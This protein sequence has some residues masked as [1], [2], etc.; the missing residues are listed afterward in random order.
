MGSGTHVIAMSEQVRAG[1]LGQA[2]F[3]EAEAAM[4]RSPGHCMTMGT[5][6]SMASIVEALGVGLPHNAAIPAADAR[7]D[8]LARLAGRRIVGHGARRPRA[9]EDPDARGVRERDPH[10]R[11]DRRL[12]ERRDPPAR[13]RRPHR[14]ELVARRFRRALPRRALPGEPDAVRQ[15]PDGG[16]LLR[17][18]LAGG[19]ARAGRAWAAAQGRADGE[20]Q[21]AVAE[22]A[23]RGVL[24]RGS[25]HAV[26]PAPQA[27]RR[28]RR[29]ARQSRA[30]RRRDQTLGRVARAAEAH[31]P[32]RRVRIAG[33]DARRRRGRESRHRRDLHHGAEELRAEGLPGHG[34]G[35]QPADPEEAAARGRARHGPD[36]GRAD[37]GHGVR[38]GRAARGAGGRGRRAAGR[39]AHR[40]PDHARRRGA[41]P[42]PARRRRASS[43]SAW[44]AGNRRPRTR[45]AAIRSY[46]SITCCRPTAA[47]TSTSS[48][49]AA[50]RPSAATITR[51]EGHGN[52]CD[53]SAPTAASSPWR[54]RS[55]T[56]TARSISTASAAASTS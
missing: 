11:G 47:R 1:E 30:E 29:A 10:A 3:R 9:L 27:R 2:E 43:R 6:S 34:R 41:Q 56:T 13:D 18:R 55:S 46:T 22:R 15:V 26:R 38:H 37:V 7:R 54:R 52:A 5:A 51:R 4:N 25:H 48:S 36:L 8:T 19:A 40:R 35:R 32:R 12:D 14:R 23:G 53:R 45:R 50:A 24:E 21:D 17:R 16:L 28:H 49:A 20:R 31:G 39:R 42:A 33:R 44:P